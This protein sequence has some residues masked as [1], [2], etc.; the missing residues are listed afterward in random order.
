MTTQDLNQNTQT[1]TDTATLAL[2]GLPSGEKV[3]A[4]TVFADG[5]LLLS[6]ILEIITLSDGN[7]N[8]KYNIGPYMPYAEGAISVPIVQAIIAIPNAEL[9][10][11]HAK[12][13]AKTGQ[14]VLPETS[15]ILPS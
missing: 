14:I 9:R 1:M 3:I 10:A 5:S 13:F 7:G 8:Y 4:D 11:A 6:N 15:L 2:I 12:Q